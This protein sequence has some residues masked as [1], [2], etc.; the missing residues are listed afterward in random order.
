[1]VK[2]RRRGR[3]RRDTTNK[4]REKVPHKLPENSAD[5]KS[6]KQ[7]DEWCAT[8]KSTIHIVVEAASTGIITREPLVIRYSCGLEIPTSQY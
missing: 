2:S 5:P 1:M 4:A 8:E 3:R 6:S 7:T